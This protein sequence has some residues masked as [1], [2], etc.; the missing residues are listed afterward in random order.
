MIVLVPKTEGLSIKEVFA[1]YS[2]RHNLHE[3]DSDDIP[4]VGRKISDI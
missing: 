1:E 4:L 3:F 2:R